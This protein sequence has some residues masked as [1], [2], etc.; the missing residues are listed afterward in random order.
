MASCRIINLWTVPYST[1]KKS[2]TSCIPPLI[3]FCACSNQDPN[4]VTELHQTQPF[5]ETLHR[6][7]W[8]LH[9]SIDQPLFRL[10]AIEFWDCIGEWIQ[11][12]ER[13]N[14]TLDAMTRIFA[15]F[16]IS[17]ALLCALYIER[18]ADP[19]SMEEEL[20]KK[21][22]PHFTEKTIEFIMSSKT[23]WMETISAKTL[24]SASSAD[25]ARFAIEYPIRKL[26]TAI[27][28]QQIDGQRFI[29]DPLGFEETVHRVTG[30]TKTECTLLM[31][32]L[33]RRISLT[34]AQI[35][36]R[37]RI[38]SKKLQC[39]Q[40]TT[41]YIINRLTSNYNLE[42]IQYQL[43]IQGTLPQK[44]CDSIHNLLEYLLE[45][46]KV[47]HPDVGEHKFVESFFDIISSAMVMNDADSDTD[48]G[49]STGTNPRTIPWICPFDGHLNKTK[50]V[51]YR[52]TFNLS[53]CSLCGFGYK[54]V[55]VMALKQIPSPFLKEESDFKI[56]DSKPVLISSKSSKSGHRRATTARSPFAGGHHNAAVEMPSKNILHIKRC[57]ND[58]RMDLHC[59]VQKDASL[60][61][62]VK[63]IARILLRHRRYRVL[64]ATQDDY[65]LNAY[66]L[67][68][69]SVFVKKRKV[70]CY[71]WYRTKLRQTTETILKGKDPE[72]MNKNTINTVMDQLRKVLGDDDHSVYRI[73][74][75]FGD[76]G[77]C[78]E[79][80]TVLTESTEMDTETAQSVYKEMRVEL[81]QF[82][83]DGYRQYIT[84][85]ANSHDVEADYQHIER[86]H[87]CHAPGPRRRAFLSFFEDVVYENGDR[88]E[89]DDSIFEEEEKSDGIMK[90]LDDIHLKLCRDD[91]DAKAD[92]VRGSM[93]MVSPRYRLDSV[94][95]SQQGWDIRTMRNTPGNQSKHIFFG[96]E[97][98][99]E[100]T[101]L[102][103]PQQ[104]QALKMTKY[105][106]E[107]DTLT[108]TGY[109]VEV[110]Y[111]DLRPQYGSIRE[112]I[113]G[114]V[115]HKTFM[116]VLREAI[117]IQRKWKEGQV[118]RRSREYSA[119]HGI[120]RNECITIKHLVAI[121]IYAKDNE[122]GCF[123]CVHL[124]DVIRSPSH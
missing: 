12:D 13:Y 27:I 123:L 64:I 72:E 86:Y 65:M 67:T 115:D 98:A 42:D 92:R 91:G 119:K 71:D 104:E 70:D 43:Q 38:K 22:T 15:D 101:S 8:P 45:Q 103:S 23:E 4:R 35:L 33:L 82:M 78:D 7:L 93:D 124:C 52:R 97:Q 60:C 25:C 102:L 18:T 17:G 58:K 55:I 96:N 79:F 94:T 40:W 109:G 77:Q 73:A 6:N 54:E 46:N 114:I 32:M 14:S 95:P 118:G 50:I 121:L 106:T 90:V 59:T 108:E 31:E 39:I 110:N 61:P 88:M 107:T 68:H 36:E 49:Q 29:S 2:P 5:E 66:D 24:H 120:L 21:L 112:E 80:S 9:K 75:H 63:R 51:E 11:S 34:D 37:I 16:H 83:I 69:L 84:D 44:F 99:N 113:E 1:F 57:A 47:E 48:N 26:K 3:L 76:K 117:E 87:L 100:V 81:R 20:T 10:N 122:F 41:D 62:F 89:Y 53:K 28:E 19:S 30:W 74:T 111:I 85:W 105:V 116:S 56:P